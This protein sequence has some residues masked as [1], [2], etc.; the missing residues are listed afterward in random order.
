VADKD[1]TSILNNEMDPQTA[2]ESLV[3]AA[4]KAGGHDNITTLVIDWLGNR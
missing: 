4:N 2:C 3:A 1:I